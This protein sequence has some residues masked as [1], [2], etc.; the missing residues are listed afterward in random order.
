MTMRA[1]SECRAAA[2][3]SPREPRTKI[4]PARIG[5]DTKDSG[6]WHRKAATT[7][8]PHRLIAIFVRPKAVNKDVSGGE[9]HR[10]AILHD[11]GLRKRIS[12]EF[13]AE[14]SK[15]V[16]LLLVIRRERATITR[17]LDEDRATVGMPCTSP[18]VTKGLLRGSH[19]QRDSIPC[20]STP[21]SPR[22]G[23]IDS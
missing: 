21:V 16:R 8:S 6:T 12:R 11:T 14:R 5:G 9:W 7:G 18:E 15:A 2:A 23:A 20:P 13:R 17:S 4:A 1:R 3:R 10:A 22:S 19:A